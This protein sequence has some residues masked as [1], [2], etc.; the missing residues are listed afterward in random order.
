LFRSVLTELIKKNPAIN[1]TTTNPAS[2]LRKFLKF[3]AE[4][5]NKQGFNF[6]GMDL[7]LH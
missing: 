7:A 1:R 3:I 2:T 6:T 5:Q 4:L